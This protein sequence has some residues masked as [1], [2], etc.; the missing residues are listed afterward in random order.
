MTKKLII[1]IDGPAYSGK[2]SAAKLLAEEF[3][4]YYI[5]SGLLYRAIAYILIKKLN[6]SLEKVKFIE[7]KELCKILNINNISYKYKNFKDA[8]IYYN[9]QSITSYLKA[10]RVSNWASV[11]STNLAI[12]EIITNYQRRLA[13]EHSV[14]IEG[15]DAGSVVFP[16]ADYKFF[17]TASIKVRAERCK[18]FQQKYKSQK[19]SLEKCIK[20]IKERDYRDKAR[21]IAPLTIPKNAIIIDNSNLDLNQTVD[22]IKSKINSH[23]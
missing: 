9:N 2:S 18:F 13:K 17:L 20:I 11:L 22:L 5:N 16:N 19:N 4:Y 14:I 12:R 7:K 1:T 15:R 23:N 6:L 10:T 8:T 3:N 21:K